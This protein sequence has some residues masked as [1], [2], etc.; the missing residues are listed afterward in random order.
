MESKKILRIVL[1]ILGGEIALII[2]ATVAQEV[3]F[4]GINFHS[5]SPFELIFGGLATTVAAILSGIVGR[6]IIKKDHKAVPIGISILITAEM[7]FLI[8]TNKTGDP[9]WFDIIAGSSLILGIW[10][11]FYYSK[12]IEALHPLFKKRR[13][14]S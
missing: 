8:L 9:A 3:L 5:S 6:L 2:L 4:D 10:I 12:I 13:V 11:G 14:T 7:T 1:A